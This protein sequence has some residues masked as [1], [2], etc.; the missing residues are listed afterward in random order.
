MGAEARVLLA[1][2]QSLRARATDC[3]AAPGLKRK[4]ARAAYDAVRD[5]LVHEELAAVPLAR[6]KETTEGR[7]RFGAIEDAGIKTVGR[8]LAAGEY[9]LERIDGVGSGTSRKVIGAARQ[10]ES[11]LRDSVRVR[12]DPRGRPTD[13]GTL[14]AMLG[15]FEVASDAV[16][17]VDA[18]L[19]E[20][21]SDLGVLI[22]LA[23][24]GA[25]R[26]KM[27]FSRSSKRRETRDALESLEER[28][29]RASTDGLV[30]AVERI[31][32]LLGGPPPSAADLWAD[33]ERRSVHYNGLLIEVAGLAPDLAATQGFIAAEIAERVQ[34]HPLDTSMLK[35]VS[36]RGYQAFGARFALCQQRVMLG[37]EMGLGKTIEALAALSHHWAEG[38]SHFLVVCPASVLVNW[39]HEARRHSHF[40]AYR[41]H[42]DEMKRNLLAWARRGGIGVTTYQALSS[43]AVPDG[44]EV[45]AM[46]VDEAHYV[47]N[48]SALRTRAVAAW[49]PRVSRVLFLTG[50]PMENRVDEFRSLVGH[51]QPE[52][53][54][55]VR[56]VDGL[57][58]ANVFRQ[59]V[60][61]VYLR[62]N[63]KDVLEEL[64]DKIETDEWVALDGEDFDAYRDAVL[65]GNFMAMRRAAYSP[66]STDGSAKL[67]RLAEIVEEAARNGRKTVVFSYF[68]A[69]LATVVEVLGDQALGPLTGNVSPIDRQALV[70]EFTASVE[71][72]VLVSQIEAGGVGLNMQTASVVILTEPQWKPSIEAQAIARC[73]RMGQIHPVNVHRLLAEDSVDERM[74]EILESKRLLIDHYVASAVTEASPDAVDVSD[75]TATKQA[76]SQVEA[77]RRIIEMER[78]RLGIDDAL[79]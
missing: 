74:L 78:R 26:F 23:A 7:V 65:S 37:D 71:P 46:V 67:D 76:A 50:T 14:L 77:E 56:G 10:L 66:G 4:A 58:G 6:L 2:A 16:R 33:Y 47:K 25:N 59:A 36:L 68:R 52:V 19:A 62:R 75:A 63:Q 57:A 12:F 40:D 48:P 69:V 55:R 79:V 32:D 61:P 41:L 72:L 49:L 64:P 13:Q 3:C 18:S 1:E 28:L 8:A 20:L 35:D 39:T 44:T 70:D 60:S 22:P 43:V 54:A 17:H 21:N 30:S 24:Q 51:L 53:A 27:V 34:A 29:A 42:G 73:H 5:R 11:A 9:G 38:A 15:S 31:V 45:A